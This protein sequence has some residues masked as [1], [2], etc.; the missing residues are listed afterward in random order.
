M[1]VTCLE[2]S[3]RAGVVAVGVAGKW[4]GRTVGAT[5]LISQWG[6]LYIGRQQSEGLAAGPM[7]LQPLIG[8]RAQHHQYI[9]IPEE[10]TFQKL[11]QG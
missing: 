10:L 2:L 8:C 7:T 5:P 1:V 3:T 11:A 4:S 6:A 9:N